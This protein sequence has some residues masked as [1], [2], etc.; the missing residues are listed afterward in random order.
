MASPARTTSPAASAA[1]RR[2]IALLVVEDS[3]DDY[4]LLLARLKSGGLTVTARRVE[5][6]SALQ[7]AL[8]GARWSAVVSDHR[9]PRFSSIEALAMVRAHDPDMPFLIV[10]GAIGEEAA[11]EAMRAG[12]DDYLMKD[13]L[14]RLVPALERALDTASVRRAQR[15]GER[16]LAESEERFRALSANLPG[17]VFQLEARDDALTLLYASDGSRARRAGRPE[18]APTGDPGRRAAPPD[19]CR[20]AGATRRSHRAG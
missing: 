17:M 20:T 4:L 18:T 7:E 10:S 8:A 1:P 16:A 2:A 19:A 6:A 11:V 9:L 3:D 15:D 13:K 12:A 5:T 14:S